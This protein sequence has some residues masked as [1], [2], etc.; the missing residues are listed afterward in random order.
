M[1]THIAGKILT[2]IFSISVC[3]SFNNK[4]LKFTFLTARIIWKTMQQKTELE[5]FNNDL[6]YS[7]HKGKAD[8]DSPFSTK[9][10]PEQWQLVGT[11]KALSAPNK[12]DLCYPRSAGMTWKRSSI[13]TCMGSC[14]LWEH[15]QLFSLGS[16][17]PHYSEGTVSSTS[18]HSMSCWKV[19][20]T[21]ACVQW[22]VA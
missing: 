16:S 6:V 14:L 7:Y 9:L 12:R 17:K 5:Y 18:V 8:N 1:N 22:C 21:K 4:L 3:C 15:C 11:F 19:I 13:P 10:F 20:N 2:Q